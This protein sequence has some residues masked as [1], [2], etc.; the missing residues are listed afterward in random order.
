M[1]AKEPRAG[2]K[3]QR[4]HEAEVQ[5]LDE[6]EQRWPFL[7]LGRWVAGDDEP[8]LLRRRQREERAHAEEYAGQCPPQ[9]RWRHRDVCL[10]QP[11]PGADGDRRPTG[12]QSGIEREELLD[13]AIVER[14]FLPDDGRCVGVDGVE[15]RPQGKR[16]GEAMTAQPEQTGHDRRWG[17]DGK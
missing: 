14:V 4:D 2:R 1:P 12:N 7:I 5:Q 10:T 16:R 15:R 8:D 17:D 13:V 9:S 6:P 3:Q 11:R